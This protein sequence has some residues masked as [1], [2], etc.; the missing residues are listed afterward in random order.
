MDLL[1]LEY[2]RV[3][4]Y[5]QHVLR[6]AEKLH[7][8]QPALSMIIKRLENSLGVSLFDRIGRSIELNRYGELYLDYVEQVFTALDN[9]SL[10]LQQAA[11]LESQKLRIALLSPYMWQDLIDVFSAKN[12][13]ISISHI[14]ES[15]NFDKYIIRGEVDFYIGALDSSFDTISSIALYQDNM[16]LMVNKNHPLA[17][18][19]HIDLIDAKNEKFIMLPSNTSL[20]KFNNLMCKLAGFTP[21]VALECDYSLRE[22]MVSHGYGVSLTTKRSALIS[23]TSDIVALNIDSPN[24][25]RAL[26]LAWKKGRIMTTPMK[27]FY[28]FAVNYYSAYY[29]DAI[30]EN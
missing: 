9:G 13:D 20:Q 21:Q 25:K 30:K 22:A 3:L 8:S 7:I 24:I 1:Q 19:K 29:P 12:P 26:Y 5:E 23:Q 10:A 16:I 17:D 2:F 28:T 27:N 11:K 14:I 4:A 15:T 6:A 18:R